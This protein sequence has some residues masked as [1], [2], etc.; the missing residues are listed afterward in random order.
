MNAAPRA[1]ALVVG[2]MTTLVG[3]ADDGPTAGARAR[4]A[5]VRHLAEREGLSAAWG[6]MSRAELQF[7]D[8]LTSMACVDPSGRQRVVELGVDCL[9]G[10]GVPVRWMGERGHLRVHGHGRYRLAV[11]GRV[12]V[13]EIFTRPELAVVVD[14][15]V[16]WSQPVAADGSFAPAIELDAAGW[17]DVYL[18]LSSIG[19]PWRASTKL[20]LARLVRVDWEPAQP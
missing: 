2:A 16:R 8:G 1:L 13:G 17:H 7:E 4:E 6:L 11:E 12:E 5:F 15:A 19:D 20:G 18:A 14:G 3:C 9:T 10:A